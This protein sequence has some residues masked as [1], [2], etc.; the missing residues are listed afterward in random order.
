[1]INVGNTRYAKS[2]Q[3]VIGDTIGI[4]QLD[5]D[6]GESSSFR[7]IAPEGVYNIKVTDGKTT[8]TQS[9]VALTGNVIGILDDK[10]LSRS[11]LTSTGVTGEEAPYGEDESV[12]AFKSNSL[13]YIFLFVL[14]GAGILLAI[15]K[16][17]RRKALTN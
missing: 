5:L 6:V 2:V 14:F 9:G 4:K 13:V 11:P 3:I 1:I 10:E 12:S 8:F 7:L 16:R 17:F 15:E